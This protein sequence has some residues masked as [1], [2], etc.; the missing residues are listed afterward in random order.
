VTTL[1]GRTDPD[2]TL[3]LDIDIKHSDG[4]G[5]DYVLNGALRRRSMSTQKASGRLTDR[6]DPGPTQE[7][8]AFSAP[9]STS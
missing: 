9:K 6:T 7:A 4:H 8:T 5:G 1:A 3:K 2:L